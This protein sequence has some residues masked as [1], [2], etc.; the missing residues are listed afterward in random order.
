MNVGVW[1]DLRN[2]PRWRRP[3]A[4]LYAATLEQ[5]EEAEALGLHSIWVSEHHGF[6]DDYLP[7]PLTFAAAI[8]ARTK[9]VRI[10]T[11]ALLAPLYLH[12]A[13][14]E[15]TALVDII[16]GG[17]LDLGLGAGYRAPEFAL[18]GRDMKGRFA[19]LDA[20][21]DRLRELWGSGAV[22]PVPIQEPL[23]IWIGLQTPKGARRVGL[24]GER[25]L[26]GNPTLWPAY[27]D[28]LA[29]AGHPPERGVMTGAIV[30]FVSEDP[31][32]DWVGIKHHLA[33]QWDTYRRYTVEGTDQPVPPPVDPDE[34]RGQG[35]AAR[36]GDGFF[37]GT[38]EEWRDAL[39]ARY[40]G[41]PM[42]TVFFVGSIASL[43]DDVVARQL[44][45][46]TRLA[47]LVRDEPLD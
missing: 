47:G 7:Q 31:E 5:C 20:C 36:S 27:R 8:A 28:A 25:F 35:M 2:P 18:F 26:S 19:A 43:P 24:A 46:I 38:P 10:G 30:G 12:A 3:P 32:A 4:E 34:L 23:P 16:S 9:R 6:E 33:W 21:P 42:E 37:I 22:T 17:R 45:A 29:E 40:D 1:F 15:Q 41:I 13:L 14:A 11:A 39:R 44:A